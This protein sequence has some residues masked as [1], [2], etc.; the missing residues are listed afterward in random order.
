MGEHTFITPHQ[1]MRPQPAQSPAHASPLDRGKRG[2]VES[3]RARAA[4]NAEEEAQREV[5]RQT[6][7]D[8]LEISVTNPVNLAVDPITQTIETVASS[9]KRFHPEKD[10]QTVLKELE[11]LANEPVFRKQLEHVIE[12]AYESKLQ[13]YIVAVEEASG[14]WNTQN[15]MME[16]WNLVKEMAR[17]YIPNEWLQRRMHALQEQ[18]AILAQARYRPFLWRQVEREF[19]G[20]ATAREDLASLRAIIDNP[21]YKACLQ[22]CIDI[23]PIILHSENPRLIQ[24][25]KEL[26]VATITERLR[27]LPTILETH[28]QLIQNIRIDLQHMDQPDANSKARAEWAHKRKEKKKQQHVVEAQLSHAQD[29]FKHMPG[30]FYSLV[31]RAL[32]AY[33]TAEHAKAETE[34]LRIEVADIITKMYRNQ[35]DRT[36]RYRIADRWK[37]EKKYEYF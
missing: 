27:E 23:R 13:Q 15:E 1:A 22:Q 21:N 36:R 6:M 3:T 16:Q 2:H 26:V 7:L 31:E 17:S 24:L 19:E 32:A 37:G 35:T 30:P 12:T 4:A 20:V 18:W 10:E 8:M 34:R 25:W 29:V 11:A 28:P 33:T 9:I 14:E 5:N